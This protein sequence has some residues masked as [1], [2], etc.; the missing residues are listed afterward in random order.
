MKRARSIV[1]WLAAPLLALALF[2]AHPASARVSEDYQRLADRF[3]Q[4]VADPV[5]GLH[6]AARMD[7]AR[8][9][10]AMLKDAGRREREHWVYMTERRIALARASA[11]AEVLEAQR[12]D[13]QRKND[14]L[15]LALARRDAEQARAELERQRLQTQI[16]AEEAERSQQA[17]D[18]ARAEGEQAAQAAVDARAEADQAKRMAAAQARATALARKEAELEAAVGGKA[19]TSP[20]HDSAPARRTLAVAESA[21]VKGNATFAPGASRQIEKAVTFVNS[22]PGAKV[23]ID[24][25]ADTRSLA[26][27]RAAAIRSAL[28]AAGIKAARISTAGSASKSGHIEIALD[29]G[30]N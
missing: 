1:P 10:L 30:K 26:Q 2:G 25:R 18:A 3:D 17:A 13:L 9:S 22:A 11:E 4:L 24:V 21:F 8:T 5:L 15:Q 27:K 28:V 6:A 20:K 12:V 7:E 19:A 16:R 14:H 23:R 29:G